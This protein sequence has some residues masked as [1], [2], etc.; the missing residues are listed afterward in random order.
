MHEIGHAIGL[1]HVVS[2]D[3]A[4]LMEP[5]VELSFDGPQLDD[6]RGLHHL[7]G[8]RLEKTPGGAGNNT[9][10]TATDLGLLPAGAAISLGGD[11]GPDTVVAPAD[12]DF[13]SIS[14]GLNPDFFAFEIAEPAHLDVRVTPLGGQ[15]HQG[16]VGRAELL[17]DAFS[18]SDVGFVV[19]AA[20]ATLLADVNHQPAGGPE[21]MH[22]LLLPA[23]GKY[24]VEV[25]GSREVALLYQLDVALSSAAVPEPPCL[26][27][28]VIAAVSC[29][30]LRR[31]RR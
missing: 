18:S 14:G 6:I 27:M 4:F 30:F 25:T 26:A 21:L 31:R 10:S 19:L 16:V 2:G 7:Y 23:A 5:V 24:F 13:L 3:A 11:A 17:T 29:C 9:L 28:L 8:D 22:S 12:D 15:F 20:D 1:D